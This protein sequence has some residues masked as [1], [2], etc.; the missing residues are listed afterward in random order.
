MK[1]TTDRKGIVIENASLSKPCVFLLS[2]HIAIL[3]TFA[4]IVV[5]GTRPLSL[6]QVEAIFFPLFSS[7][8]GAK[9]HGGFTNAGS[10]KLLV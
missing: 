1:Q 3:F 4:P 8:D 9:K 2:Q 7:I 5:M 10:G 6:S